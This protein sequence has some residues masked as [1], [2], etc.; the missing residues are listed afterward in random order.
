MASWNTL[1]IPARKN[2]LRE[3]FNSNKDA[4]LARMP[5]GVNAERLMKIAINA[6]TQNPK[7]L[8]CT[9]QSVMRSML[10]CLELGLEPNTPLGQAYLIPFKSDCTLVIGYKGYIGLAYKSNVIEYI[11]YGLVYSNEEY[12]IERGLNPIFKHIP[13]MDS[14][15]RGDFIF[16]YCI[17]GISGSNRAL[18]YTLTENEI[19]ERERS[20]KMAGKG[21]WASSRDAMRLKTVIRHALNKAPLSPEERLA[22]A[23]AYDKEES[24]EENGV[25][26]VDDDTFAEV[27]GED[28]DVD[29]EDVATE[30]ERVANQIKKKKSNGNG[31]KNFNT[32]APNTDDSGEGDQPLPFEN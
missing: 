16:A 21:A 31:K 12:V 30:T 17:I 19:K 28:D 24:Y 2:S 22:M 1:P 11:D 5:R 13:I 8:D 25:A 7:L 6:V 27:V 9:R 20:S 26:V 14:A 18:L 29:G 4:I 15:E 23:M 10:Q 3:L 32:P